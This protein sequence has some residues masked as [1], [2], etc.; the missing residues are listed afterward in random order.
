MST[1]NSVGSSNSYV[2]QQARPNKADME[3]KLQSEFENFDSSGNGSLD[4]SELTEMMG[5]M[6]TPPNGSS[7]SS[8]VANKIF[9]TSDSDGN[10]ELSLDELKSGMEKMHEEMKAKGDA[11]RMKMGGGKNGGGGF[12][13]DMQ[14]LA[15][16]IDSGD[17]SSAKDILSAIQSH[18]P[19]ESKNGSESASSQRE[20]DFDALSKAL[21]SGDTT[22]AKSALETIQSHMSQNS[23][24]SSQDNSSSAQNYDLQSMLM[25]LFTQNMSSSSSDISSL[26]AVSA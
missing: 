26:L 5:N 19:K 14:S 21:E 1:I 12:E 3:A 15:D 4:I 20:D 16:A 6:P 7:D 23:N 17:L 9:S 22:A 2:Q 25:K 24:N 13:Q 8:S 11:M 10:G 18:K